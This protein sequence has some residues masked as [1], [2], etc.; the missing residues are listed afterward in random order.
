MV[1]ISWQFCSIGVT[2]KLPC[3]PSRDSEQK[4]QQSQAH[5]RSET[6][7]S[8]IIYMS[9]LSIQRLPNFWFKDLQTWQTGVEASPDEIGTRCQTSLAGTSLESW[10]M[11]D[12]VETLNKSF[13]NYH[14]QGSGKV[15]STCNRKEQR[16]ICRDLPWSGLWKENGV[17]DSWTICIPVK[18]NP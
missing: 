18:I 5:G 8:F 10:T 13:R 4:R 12:D 6:K 11:S 3:P 15:K 9:R 7:T 1:Y 17:Q 2:Y 14:R 16:P